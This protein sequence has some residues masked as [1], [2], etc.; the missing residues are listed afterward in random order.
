MNYS[1]F[2]MN[3]EDFFGIEDKNFSH[4]KFSSKRNK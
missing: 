3:N 2:I 1:G 4:S